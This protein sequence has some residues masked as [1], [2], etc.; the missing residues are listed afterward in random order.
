MKMW[1][2]IAGGFICVGLILFVVVMSIL[3]WNFARLSTVESVTNTHQISKTVFSIDL[4]TVTADVEILP[5]E[6]DTVQVVCQEYA[7]QTHT[8]QVE[9]GVL[10]IQ[11]VDERAWYEHIAIQFGMTKVTVYLPQR[12][13][14]QVSVKTSTGKIKVENLDAVRMDMEITTGSLQLKDVDCVDIL[15]LQ[16]STGDVTL[17]EVRCATLETQGKTGDMMLKHVLAYESLN[18]R[19]TT[20][21]I[22]LEDS[23]G[24][25]MTITTT[26]GDVKGNLLTE[27]RFLAKTST[28]K[29]QVPDTFSGGLCKITTSTGDIIITCP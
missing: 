8:V 6:D 1:M 19:S 15:N 7:K 29:V 12:R 23:E 4:Q 26:T 24:E 10:K 28:G 14:D 20:G 3:G 21:D 25:D 5:S 27:K 11:M 18:I 2:I 9:E 16:V 13:Y 17:T 22:V